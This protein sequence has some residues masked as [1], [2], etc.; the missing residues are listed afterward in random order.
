M[1]NISFIDTRNMP[2]SVWLEHRRRTIGG[3]DA[4]A[5]L[6]LHRN[7]TPMTVWADKTGRLPPEEETEAMRQGR[8]LEPYVVERWC[9]ETGKKVH[10]VNRM[11]YHPSYPY[12]HADIDRKVVGE[13]AG[14]ECKTISAWDA[15]DK[16][17]NGEYPAH[18]Y[19]QCVHYMAITGADRWYLA[20]LVLGRG[21][22]CFVI[23]RNEDEIAALMEQETAFWETYVLTDVPPPVDGEVPTTDALKKMYPDTVSADVR[24]DDD[25]LSRYDEFRTERDTAAKKLELAKQAIMLK[26]AES[27]TGYSDAYEVKWKQQQRKNYDVRKFM[28]DH[29]EID[30]TPY[31][32]V[33]SYRVFDVK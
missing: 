2:R 28:R 13:N 21:F 4:A 11:L 5:I 3:S 15:E 22:Y 14:L 23:E 1:H 6:G 16:L 26:M 25:L 8:D 9:E 10:R 24:L 32:K 31:L 30:M 18:Y 29:P 33:T 12:A 20:V 7:S 17:E 27:E 19:V